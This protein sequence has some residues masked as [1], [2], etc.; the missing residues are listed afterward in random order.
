[1]S[2]ALDLMSYTLCSFTQECYKSHE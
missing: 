2:L 1:V